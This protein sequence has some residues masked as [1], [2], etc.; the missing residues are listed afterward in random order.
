MEPQ[1]LEPPSD[2][3]NAEPEEWTE[4][5]DE[6]ESRNMYEAI[7]DQVVLLPPMTEPGGAT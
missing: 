7:N 5:L 2:P 3:G 6:Y 4:D 1:H